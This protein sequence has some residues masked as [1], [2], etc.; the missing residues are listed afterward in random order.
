MYNKKGKIK[1][2][3]CTDSN[4]VF[5]SRS[6][7]PMQTVSH[8]LSQVYKLLFKFVNANYTLHKFTV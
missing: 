5:H 1:K 8:A 6:T 4:Q 3:L 7:Y 2:V